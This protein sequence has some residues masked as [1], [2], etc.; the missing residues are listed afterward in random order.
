MVEKP[1]PNTSLADRE[2]QKCEEQFKAFEENVQQLT[3]DRMN[4]APKE[5]IEPQTK[6]AQRDLEKSSEVYLKPFRTISSKEK[7]NE[8]YRSDYEFA[9]EHVRF[10]AEHKEL[11]GE[12]IDLWTK[13]YPGMP[14]EEWKIPT[15]KPVWGPRYLAERLHACHYH[16]L[17]MQQNVITGGDQ[18]GSQY[19]GQMAADTTVQRLDAI[20]V[21]N[22]KSIYMGASGF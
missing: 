9:K 2:L 5:D 15:G 17:V 14:A 13:P 4:Q 12:T 10:I 16:R 1:K 22:R 7:F 21:S 18:M 19:F 6:I 8:R 3:L 20:P 11:Q